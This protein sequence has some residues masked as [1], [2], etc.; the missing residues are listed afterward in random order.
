MRW[1]QS[2]DICWLRVNPG[3]CKTELGR[4]NDSWV[5]TIMLAILARTS[6]M[7]SRTLTHAAIGSDGENFKGEYLSNCKVDE[8]PPESLPPISLSQ[9]LTSGSLLFT[10]VYSWPP[11][12][13]NPDPTVSHRRTNLRMSPFVMSE[14]GKETGSKL[15]SEMIEI[16]APLSPDIDKLF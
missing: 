9:S 6:E 16:L 3:L 7:G 8:Y 10:R 11:L 2:S 15:W 4:E 13:W 1:F 5:F 14:K 12:L